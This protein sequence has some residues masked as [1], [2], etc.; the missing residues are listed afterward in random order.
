MGSDF[1]TQYVGDPDHYIPPMNPIM[2]ESTAPRGVTGATQPNGGDRSLNTMSPNDI[3][4]TCIFP[5]KT[6]NPTGIDCSTPDST[7]NPLCTKDATGKA[8]EPQINAKAYPGIRELAVVHGL[9][10]QGIAASICPQNVSDKM[11]ANYGYRPA[12]GAIIDRLKTVLG[13][14]CLPRQLHADAQGNVP[15]LVLEASHSANGQGPCTMPLGRQ[16]VSADHQAAIT[17]AKADPQAP[18]AP[19]EWNNFCEIVQFPAGMS[20]QTCQNT[21]DAMLPSSGVDGWCYIDAASTPPV[22]NSAIVASCPTNDQRL[23]RFVGQGAVQTGATAF[24]TCSG[25]TAQ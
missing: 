12:V 18:A 20:R 1:W 23:I 15:C 10:G 24:I 2:Q 3:Q 9:A 14:Q 6:P 22:G 8:T 11:Q 21:V 13:G 5:L 25:D 4:Y 16:P 19:N 17:A 7:D